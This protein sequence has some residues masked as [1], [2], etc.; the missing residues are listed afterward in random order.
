[1]NAETQGADCFLLWLSGFDTP[2]WPPE[3]PRQVCACS[4]T[5]VNFGQVLTSNEETH[6][7][8]SKKLQAPEAWSLQHKQHVRGWEVEQ[9]AESSASQ[10]IHKTH[11]CEPVVIACNSAEGAN[12]EL[13]AHQPEVTK[14]GESPMW[15]KISASCHQYDTMEKVNET[16]AVTR[17]FFTK[18]G[19]PFCWSTRG[20]LTEN[21]YQK[22]YKHKPVILSSSS[23]NCFVIVRSHR[24]LCCW[25]C[26]I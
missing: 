10:L 26:S 12:Y 21:K 5:G 25:H 13:G 2:I 3:W 23:A 8:K 17:R 14:K 1:M 15:G 20:D 9:Y 19:N 22:K 18:I 6:F 16:L 24:F 4:K 7:K 11:I